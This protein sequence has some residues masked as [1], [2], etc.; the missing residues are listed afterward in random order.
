VRSSKIDSAVR[1][2]LKFLAG[3]QLDMNTSRCRGKVDCCGMK[4]VRYYPSAAVP[5]PALP[6]GGSFPSVDASCC[7]R[8]AGGLCCLCLETVPPRRTQVLPPRVSVRPAPSG[9][10]F[11]SGCAHGGIS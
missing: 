5:P 9:V 7:C 2:R 1:S 10:A 4:A 11:P 8:R 6:A 3:F